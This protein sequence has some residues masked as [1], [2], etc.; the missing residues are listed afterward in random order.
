[1]NSETFNKFIENF[2]LQYHYIDSHHSKTGHGPLMLATLD[3]AVELV[4]SVNDIPLHVFK[5]KIELEVL[6][7]H[8][9]EY[10]AQ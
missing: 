10:A 4:A 9:H 6:A 5:N 1:M 3:D 8:L 2:A 7:L